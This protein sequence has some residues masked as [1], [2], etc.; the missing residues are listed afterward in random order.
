MITLTEALGEWQVDAPGMW[1]NDTGP[2]DW[3][4]VSNNDGIV[5]YFSTETDACRFRL[6]EI[7]RLLNG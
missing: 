1:E 7:N 4:A 3:Y 2:K 6:N 5:A